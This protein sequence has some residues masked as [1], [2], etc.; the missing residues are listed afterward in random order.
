MSGSSPSVASCQFIFAPSVFANTRVVAAPRYRPRLTAPSYRNRCRFNKLVL[1]ARDIAHDDERGNAPWRGIR[2]LLHPWR[3]TSALD[4]VQLERFS[5]PK[6][7]ALCD[8]R[9]ILSFLS[10]DNLVLEQCALCT[11]E[12]DDAFVALT[13]NRVLC[14]Q[15]AIERGASPFYIMRRI[16]RKRTSAV[17]G[18]IHKS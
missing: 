14:K 13:Q 8:E 18:M 6:P 5:A 17:I 7:E 3:V 2:G 10:L 4:Q 15:S 9:R 12:G 16:Q 11:G 1:P